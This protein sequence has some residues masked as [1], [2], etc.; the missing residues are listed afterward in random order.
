MC[1]IAGFF[2]AGDAAMLKRMTVRIAHRG[3]DDEAFLIDSDRGAFLGF[4]RLAVLDIVGGKQPMTSTDGALSFVFNGQIYN[5][6]ELRAQLEQLGARFVTDHSD[7]EVLLHGWRQWGEALPDHLN[8]MWAFAIYDRQARRVFF[9]RDRFGEKPLFY[10]AGRDAFVFASELTALREHP[11]V[12]TRLS[13]RALRK[14]FAYGY[15]PAPLTFIE[16][17]AKLPAGHSLMLNLADN[18]IRVSRY[19]QYQPEP[20]FDT[21]P[22]SELV[23]EFRAKLDAAVARRLVADVPV[24]CFLSGGIDS[25]TVTALAMRHA[26][27][28]GIKAFSI[29]FEE[30]SFDETRYACAVAE[31]VGADHQVERL[32]V[33]RALEILPELA[34]RW[35]EPIADSSTLPTYLLCQHARRQVTVALGGDGA[36]ELLAGYDPFRA[37]RYAHWYEKLVPKPVHR[38]LSLLAG[39][40]PVSHRYM[41]FDF[42]LKRTLRGLDHPAHLWLPVWM[43]PLAPSE[44]DELFRAPIAPEDVYSDAIEAWEQCPI[45]DPVERTIAF[46]IRFYLQDDI[47]VKVDRASML[48]SLEVRAPFLDID[49]VDFLRRLPVKMKLR[50]RTSKWILRRCA[51]SLLPRRVLTRGKQGFGMPIG[52]W[53]QDGTLQG[54]SC[55]INA[56][57]RASLLQEHRAQRSD[58][59]AY[60]WSDLVLGMSPLLVQQGPRT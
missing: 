49:L 25:S 48:H 51:K 1:G 28:E 17:V 47:L 16:G 22:E 5:F 54:G 55:V 10:F 56:P 43:A 8:G 30:A 19:W 34:S 7:T 14:Y 58:Q 2:G 50:G 24:G 27:K 37:L 41:S 15:V 21:R 36:D 33:Q 12:P 29:G 11:A 32:S 35:D 60:L 23:E 18:S 38:A 57:F 42:R 53:F 44:L 4:R 6:R 13:D 31:H 9:S 20:Q 52:R 39:R 46:Y 45:N 3:P 40:L 26:G 59:R